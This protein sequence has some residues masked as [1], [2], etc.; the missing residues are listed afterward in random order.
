MVWAQTD[1]ASR[2]SKTVGCRGRPGQRY[3]WILR[4]RQ[5]RCGAL[6]AVCGLFLHGMDRSPHF[7]LFIRAARGRADRPLRRDQSQIIA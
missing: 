5:G 6:R 4:Q 2:K 7:F 1:E 3:T